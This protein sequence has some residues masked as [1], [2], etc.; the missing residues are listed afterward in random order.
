MNDKLCNH[1]NILFAAAP[2]NQKAEEIKEELLTNLNDKY[3]DL[4]SNGYDST[5]A[6]H[7]ALSGIG[8]IDELLKEC[9]GTVQVDAAPISPPPQE[10]RLPVYS[11]LAFLLFCAFPVLPVI[12]NVFG[13]SFTWEL[14][15][16]FLVW[17]FAGSVI[18][19]GIV[20]S[21][22]RQSGGAESNPAV[23][24]F[25]KRKI[26]R[27]LVFVGLAI[28]IL[29][30][31]DVFSRFHPFHAIQP[32]CS[33]CYLVAGG[34]YIFALVTLFL[35]E[36]IQTE[37]YNV[38]ATS[39]YFPAPKSRLPLWLGLIAGLIV[40]LPILAPGVVPFFIV[41]GSTGVGVFCFFL[42]VAVSCGLFA[43]AITYAIASLCTGQARKTE[44]YQ[45]QLLAQ[46]EPHVSK[47]FVQSELKRIGSVNKL[48]Q[49]ALVL[50]IVLLSL[51]V[52]SVVYHAVVPW[53]TSVFGNTIT[54]TGPVIVQE[55]EVGDLSMLDIID[56]HDGVTVEFKLSD[57]NLITVETH[58]D[59]MPNIHTEIRDGTLLIAQ[60]YSNRY[61]N[62][63]KLLVTVYSPSVPKHLFQVSG[64]SRLTCEEPLKV[65]GV[66]LYASGASR[67]HFKNI[68]STGSINFKLDGASSAE[69]AGSA[70]S[71][72]IQ[73][74]GASKLQASNLD[75][76]HCEAEISGASRAELG[77]IGEL[78]VRASGASHFTYR[79]TPTIKKQD[80]S[81]ASRI[82]IFDR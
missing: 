54:P 51:F 36:P 27:M 49:V 46:A 13:R 37:G 74:S 73:A 62:V 60:Y 40:G 53:Q 77:N 61:R 64:A 50:A 47:E 17:V 3:N 72:H 8:D 24:I 63:K 1:V 81:G 68:E 34:C 22:T 39:P 52:C 16:F 19:Y 29:I 79:G 65:E 14:F 20:S 11:V 28:G 82:K 30:F 70:E 76:N 55:R 44:N 67:L 59:M 78:S 2:K 41:G 12:I 38:P 9:G 31:V 15:C 35:K 6:F 80:V 25:S 23:P 42:F 45:R 26:V 4:L 18:L 33:L 75:V 48:R 56:V 5:A 10:S 43:F 21:Y 57:R 71:V 66:S 7:I 69:V 58:A 32:F